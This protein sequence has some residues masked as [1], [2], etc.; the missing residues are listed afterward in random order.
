MV[1]D[2]NALKTCT[3]AATLPAT[4]T[5][6]GEENYCE[7]AA[8]KPRVCAPRQFLCQD[9]DVY[10]CDDYGRISY[11]AQDCGGETACQASA[12]GGAT[13]VTLTC[14]PGETSCVNNKVGKCDE[15]GSA[16]AAVTSDCTADGNVCDNANKCAKS[17]LDAMGVEKELETQSSGVAIGDVIDVT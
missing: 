1:C 6:C 3:A 12:D 8:C 5:D 15:D 14:Q 16:L 2:G 10:Y 4:G 11:L 13:C 9:K 7:N 17:V